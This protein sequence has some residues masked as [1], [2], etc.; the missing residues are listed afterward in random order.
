[1]SVSSRYIDFDVAQ[2]L[3]NYVIRDG[4]PF[5]LK[6]DDPRVT[7]PTGIRTKLCELKRDDGT[8]CSLTLNDWLSHKEDPR[9]WGGKRGIKHL[10]NLVTKA[11]KDYRP[12][13]EY[14]KGKLQQQIEDLNQEVR[15]RRHRTGQG[16]WSGGN[17]RD[18]QF[19]KELR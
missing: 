13:L 17:L 16:R 12:S 6:G 10:M 8:V 19:I 7:T 3:V 2:A 15:L 9:M 4:V 11:S 1:M 18:K 5:D 14:R